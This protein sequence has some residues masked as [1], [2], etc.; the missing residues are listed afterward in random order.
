METGNTMWT[1][2]RR[3]SADDY[4]AH[5]RDVCV[6]RGASRVVLFGSRATGRAR[7]TSDFDIAVYGVAD[8]GPRGRDRC[9]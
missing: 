5:I 3:M 9:P 1:G 2:V 8:T 4:V 7:P 6:R